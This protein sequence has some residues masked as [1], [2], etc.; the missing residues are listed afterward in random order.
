M[1][2]LL[3]CKVPAILCLPPP[4]KGRNFFPNIFLFP[5]DENPVKLIRFKDN[6]EI[7]AESQMVLDSIM[8]RSSRDACRN[9]RGTGPSV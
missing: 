7:Q 1:T 8:N 3:V 2:R 5:E 9:V 6:V 4:K